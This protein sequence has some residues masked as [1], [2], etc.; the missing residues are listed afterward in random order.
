MSLIFYC[1][2]YFNG[3][4]DR[5]SFV[6]KIK[7]AM[8]IIQFTAMHLFWIK[9][10]Q[11][12]EVLLHKFF[13]MNNLNNIYKTE[14]YANHTFKIYFIIKCMWLILGFTQDLSYVLMPIR[15]E[16][17]LFSRIV[18]IYWM[19]VCKMV[20]EVVYIYLLVELE[21][22]LNYLWHLLSQHH[23]KNK[24]IYPDIIVYIEEIEWLFQEVNRFFQ[25]P[26][27]FKITFQ[28]ILNLSA[29]DAIDLKVVYNSRLK[30][31][32][33]YYTRLG[34]IFITIIDLIIPCYVL[35]KVRNQVSYIIFKNTISINFDE[36]VNYSLEDVMMLCRVI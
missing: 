27:V 10:S 9:Q 23:F 12:C 5:L 18:A 15:N 2:I 6:L 36:I 33:F 3:T 22:R 25:G 16:N 32:Y 29:Y 35:E 26:L 28:F 14:S 7:T 17:V 24:F 20:F 34:C 19:V 31:F 21:K 1:V 4:K 8:D 30:Y 13:A 11:K